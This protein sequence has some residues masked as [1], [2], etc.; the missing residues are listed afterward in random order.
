MAKTKKGKGQGQET[1]EE[2]RV[3]VLLKLGERTTNAEAE[4]KAI[5]DLAAGLNATAE[6][7][8]VMSLLDGLRNL[9]LVCEARGV[10]M[11]LA[12]A[13]QTAKEEAKGK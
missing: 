7:G 4:L 5:A 13:G 10:A 12:V 9:P 3:R 11:S 6:M 1:V 8:K 2:R